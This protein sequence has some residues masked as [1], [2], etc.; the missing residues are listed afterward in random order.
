M[1]PPTQMPHSPWRRRRDFGRI[2]EAALRNAAHLVA[3]WLPDGRRIGRE[4]VVRNPT[5]A[6]LRPGSFKV[7]LQSGR[8]SD[9]ATGDSGGDLISLRAYLDGVRQGEAMWRIARELA[10]P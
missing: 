9:F 6:D 10:W 7:N 4:W 1:L 3:R 2:S 8:W 5:R